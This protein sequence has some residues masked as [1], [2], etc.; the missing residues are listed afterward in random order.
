MS[1]VIIVGG[2]AS[3][4]IASVMAARAGARVT[5]LEQNDKPGKKLSATGNGKCNLTNL[6]QRITVAQIRSF[7]LLPGKHFLFLIL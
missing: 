7:H 1:D 3:G 4:L 6:S 2:G 5:V